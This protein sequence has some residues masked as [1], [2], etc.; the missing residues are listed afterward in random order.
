MTSSRERGDGVATSSPDW[1]FPQGDVWLT[2][3]RGTEIDTGVTATG[4]P[5][6]ANI[7]NFVNGESIEDTDVVVWYGAHATHDVSHE[8]P[9]QF[10]H[11]VG[12]ELR[13]V[14]W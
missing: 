13:R 7:G 4:P 6:E 10:G 9:G 3:Y 5:Y 14:K 8:E 11:V 2:R 1:P 12:P